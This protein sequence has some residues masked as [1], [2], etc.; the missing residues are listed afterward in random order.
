GGSLSIAYIGAL[1]AFYQF[2]LLAIT[3]VATALW[4]V[5][6]VNALATVRYRSPALAGQAMVAGLVWTA[7]LRVE[8]LTG[9]QTA[10]LLIGV[11]GLISVLVLYHRHWLLALVGYGLML[12][13]SLAFSPLLAPL[14]AVPLFAAIGFLAV[15]LALQRYRTWISFPEV[16]YA[17]FA[18]LV[19]LL[20][21]FAGLVALQGA[22]TPLNAALSVSAMTAIAL[23]FDRE[24]LRGQTRTFFILAVALLGL[25][26]YLLRPTEWGILPSLVA[27]AT[28]T[29]VVHRN[30]HAH[31]VV[32]AALYA[33]YR[34]SQGT[35]AAMATPASLV[36][37]GLLLYALI[38]SFLLLGRRFLSREF[39]IGAGLAPL[40]PAFAVVDSVLYPVLAPALLAAVF[41]ASDRSRNASHAAILFGGFY[42]FVL[43][44][45]AA[46]AVPP[47]WVWGFIVLGIA[48]EGILLATRGLELPEG[49]PALAP[50]IGVL[51]FPLA[52]SIAVAEV[53]ILLS[54][55]LLAGALLLGLRPAMRSLRPRLTLAGLSLVFGLSLRGALGPALA[56]TQDLTILVFSLLAIA[57]FLL[58]YTLELWRPEARTIDM[59][60]VVL[61]IAP[62]ALII[63]ASAFVLPLGG[64]P[65]YL[66]P[67][68]LLIGLGYLRGDLAILHLN[69]LVAVAL[70]SFYLATVQLER[71]P[72]ALTAG[73]G[74]GLV[75]FG[76]RSRDGQHLSTPTMLAAESYVLLGAA[77]AYGLAVG[78]TLAWALVGGSLL[79]Y[80]LVFGDPWVRYGG[81]VAVFAAVAKIFIADLVGVAIEIRIAALIVVAGLLLFVSFTYARLGRKVPDTT[82]NGKGPD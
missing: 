70:L 58:W 40:I 1:S 78:T 72:V 27:L 28:Y 76:W 82:D 45:G 66:L 74:L 25:I 6:V 56:P 43:L 32:A 68:I 14:T 59:P 23:W 22:L 4:T 29:M 63:S 65:L 73:V 42:L 75:A 18:G 60:V 16:P 35:V 47:L 44:A 71:I 49:L 15:F 17:T 39:S 3:A 24:A 21:A 54:A 30:P 50:W 69:T 13:S 26:F 79:L 41:V 12:A 37:V 38:G 34:L 9:P 67:P 51:G 80:G 33:G 48:A 36:G 64:P 81:F 55:M 20:F 2:Q 19:L 11:Y 62:L 5:T 8:T 77:L 53:R 10:V 31:A 52:I 7:L 61:R 46:L 57:I